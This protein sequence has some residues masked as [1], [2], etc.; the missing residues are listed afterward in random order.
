MTYRVTR[1]LGG[2]QRRTLLGRQG[3]V[4]RLPSRPC[5]KAYHHTQSF[6]VYLL[7]HCSHQHTDVVPS[8][9]DHNT[10]S[11]PQRRTV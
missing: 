1:G 2:S 7:S 8:T 5:S 6:I 4:H 3:K 10:G 11:Y 9:L